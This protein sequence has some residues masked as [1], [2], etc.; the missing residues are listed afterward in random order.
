M[1][2]NN[3]VQK[4]AKAATG[5]APAPASAPR[6]M[7]EASNMEK[8]KRSNREPGL[9][10]VNRIESHTNR[11][12]RAEKITKRLLSELSRDILTYFLEEGKDIAKVNR[13]LGVLTPQNR[14]AASIF[15]N[16]F[17]AWKMNED[18]TFA[19]MLGKKQVEDMFPRIDNFLADPMADIWSW[20][21][22]NID[23]E[24]K[25]A[26]FV[27]AIQDAVK[28]A[29]AGAKESDK[30]IATEPLT[31]AQIMDA[32]LS[33]GISIDDAFNALTD[34]EQAQDKAA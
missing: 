6:T 19:G 33:A 32:V 21:E 8:A 24:K 25:K 14:K 15:F 20:A 12:A 23:V 29:L 27:G 1:A 18:G 16:H 7:R 10:L 9:E 22:D 2:K 31:P 26:D 28:R 13:L 5:R 30:R 4:P 11:L 17:L 34:D 3:E